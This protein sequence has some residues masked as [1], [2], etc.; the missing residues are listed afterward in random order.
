MTPPIH[1]TQNEQDPWLN[2]LAGPLFV[3]DPAQH[4]LRIREDT[5]L[6]EAQHLALANL[7]EHGVLAST[8]SPDDHLEFPIPNGAVPVSRLSDSFVA[9]F[10]DDMQEVLA[11]AEQLTGLPRSL[12]IRHLVHLNFVPE[13][14]PAVRILPTVVILY[15]AVE[16]LGTAAVEGEI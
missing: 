4:S 3:F 16:D 8:E 6:S 2:E 15:N 11:E 1:P 10:F 9:N 7:L 12:I 5:Q 13:G 14:S